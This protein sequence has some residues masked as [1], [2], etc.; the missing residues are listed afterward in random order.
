MRRLM[1][2]FRHAGMLPPAQLRRYSISET[3][4]RRSIINV[5]VL[6]CAATTSS[7]TLA[8]LRRARTP[9]PNPPLQ[10]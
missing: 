10:S 6:L 1:S 2:L 5:N 7:D 3:D 9:T 8:V 4:V